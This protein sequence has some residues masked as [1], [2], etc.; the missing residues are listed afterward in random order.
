MKLLLTSSGLADLLTSQCRELVYAGVSAG[1]MAA[2]AT[3]GEAFRNPPG[4]RR[5]RDRFRGAL[6][7]VHS[8]DL[9]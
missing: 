5:C 3:F 1:S 4:R 8:Y 6:E 7:T 9:N 2:S